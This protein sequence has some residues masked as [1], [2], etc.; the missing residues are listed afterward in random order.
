MNAFAMDAPEIHDLAFARGRVALFALLKALGVG[1][2]DHILTQAFTC[3]AV[4]EAILAVGARPVYVDLAPASVTMS[5]DDLTRKISPQTRAVIVQHTF[6]IPAEMAPILSVAERWGIP[7]IEDCC[8]TF[9]SRYQNR[10]VGTFGVGAFYSFEWGKPVT[11]GLG[12]AIRLNGHDDL[13]ASLR[14]VHG[15][16]RRP[17]LSRTI[18]LELQYRVFRIAYQP[19]VYWPMKRLY[20]VLASA[21]VAVTNYHG[22]AAI[23]ANAAEFGQIMTKPCE[24]RL[25]RW[26]QLA[27]LHRDHSVAVARTLRDQITVATHVEI[28]CG[29]APVYARYPLFVDDRQRLLGEAERCGIELAGWYESAVHPLR[30]ENLQKAGY[31]LGSCPNAE[32]AARRVVSLPTHRKTSFR[33]ADKA[34]AF[35]NA[36]CR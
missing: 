35:I 24:L 34:A 19:A 32:L 26:E 9:L 30:G 28:P 36:N 1:R 25:R 12:G 13:E 29:S 20:R 2:G 7:V 6:G 18:K 27:T 17:T 11:L 22:E 14:E 21:G 16:L 3:V 33:Y 15:T 4:P 5:A 10:Y 23:D 31:E 8:H